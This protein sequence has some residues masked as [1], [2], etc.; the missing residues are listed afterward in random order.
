MGLTYCTEGAEYPRGTEGHLDVLYHGGKPYRVITT[1][2]PKRNSADIRWGDTL[3][4]DGKQSDVKKA[5]EKFGYPTPTR[6]RAM[7]C[8][9][10]VDKEGQKPEVLITGSLIRM[11]NT[12]EE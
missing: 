1:F 11:R 10:V 5:R 4:L 7:I 3:F 12:S 9:E 6:G 2:D 8:E